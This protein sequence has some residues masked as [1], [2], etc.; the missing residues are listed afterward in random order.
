MFQ[1]YVLPAALPLK[2]AR[3]G[4]DGGLRPHFATA[5][6]RVF[7]RRPAL[8]PLPIV[9]WAQF[10]YLEWEGRDVAT[11]FD[12]CH[13]RKKD[14]FAQPLP[15]VICTVFVGI[16]PASPRK[17]WG[18]KVGDVRAREVALSRAKVGQLGESA[19]ALGSEQGRAG[20]AAWEADRE[21]GRFR[22]DKNLQSIFA[23]LADLLL[24]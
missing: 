24:L 18:H 13:G 12:L 2:W 11:T 19:F 23:L 14:R 9:T 7:L 6:A 22:A 10:V 16:L 17:E 5:C 15:V 3:K 8:H 1:R 4:S 20:L 21:R